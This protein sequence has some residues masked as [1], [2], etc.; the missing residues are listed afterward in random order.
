M[1]NSFSN[2]AAAAFIALTNKF[3][4]KIIFGIEQKVKNNY[5]ELRFEFHGVFG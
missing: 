1:N 2:A 3:Q 5:F 4:L